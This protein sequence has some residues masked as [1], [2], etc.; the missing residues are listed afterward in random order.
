METATA[1]FGQSCPLEHSFPSAVHG[2]A[3]HAASYPDAMQANAAAGG[4]NAGRAG[5]LGAWLGAHLGLNAIPS[6]WRE[7]LTAHTQIEVSVE[8]LLAVGIA[9]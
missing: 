8:K 6:A 4:D 5:M 3:K 9:R 2:L 1:E 7:R